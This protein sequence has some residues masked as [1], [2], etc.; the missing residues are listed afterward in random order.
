MTLNKIFFH[1]LNAKSNLSYKQA[2]KKFLAAIFIEEYKKV[3]RVDIIF[4]SDEYLLILNQ[5]FLK[6][7]YYTD[8]LSFILSE[9]NAPITGEIYVSISRIKSNA[10]QLK[11]PYQIELRRVIIHGC[12]HLCG[13]LDSP[14]NLKNKM[15]A[16]QEKYLDRW[17]VS[18]ETQIGG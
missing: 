3:N 9:K 18:R 7:N 12:L 14:K 4:C 6:H 17:I 13:Y 8:T 1:D 16:I 10:K 15:Q 2:L 11:I 5:Q